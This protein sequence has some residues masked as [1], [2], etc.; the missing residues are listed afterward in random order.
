MMVHTDSE[1]EVVHPQLAVA[2]SGLNIC[3]ADENAEHLPEVERF[4]RMV[5]EQAWCLYHSVPFHHFPTLLIKELVTACIFW[6]N[7]FPPHDGV[8]ATL[9]PCTLMSGFDLDYNKH[10][11]LEFGA[12]TSLHMRSMT[13]PCSLALLELSHCGLLATIRVDTIL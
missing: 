4:I 6:L 2:R 7:M 12:Y 9:S 8:S 10:C 1:F 11:R 3:S 13:T 5:K